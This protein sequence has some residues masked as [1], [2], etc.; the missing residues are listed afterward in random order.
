MLYR[1]LLNYFRIK[2]LRY[3]LVLFM[4][5]KFAKTKNMKTIGVLAFALEYFLASK[6]KPTKPKKA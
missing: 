6:K 4:G 2:L 3:F 1:L 5:S